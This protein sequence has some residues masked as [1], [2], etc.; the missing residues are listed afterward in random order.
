MLDG[1]MIKYMLAISIF[2]LGFSK[3]AISMDTL[4][5][6]GDDN[7]LPV[8]YQNENGDI[9]GIDV[10]ILNEVALRAGFK[11]SIELAPWKRVLRDLERGYID[12]AFPLAKTPRREE[13]GIFI[14]VP[15]HTFT[16]S[17]FTKPNSKF[18]YNSFKDLIGKRVGMQLGFSISPDFDEAVKNEVIQALEVESIEQLTKMMASDRIDVFVAKPSHMAIYL[19]NSDVKLSKIGDVSERFGAFLVMSKKAEFKNKKEIINRINHAMREIRDDGTMSEIVN[20]Y[21]PDMNFNN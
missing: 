9:V 10:D 16:F 1:F 18:K 4:I 8:S 6:H 2:V 17:A 7:N 12:G 11:V 14:E 15:I 20:K 13:Y 3:F 19:S 21:I 5:F